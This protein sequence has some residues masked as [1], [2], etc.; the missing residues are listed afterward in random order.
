MTPDEKFE[1]WLNTVEGKTCSRDDLLYLE[2]YKPIYMK[3]MKAAFIAGLKSKLLT[4]PSS[5]D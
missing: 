2:S 4:S 3:R 5:V 1:E